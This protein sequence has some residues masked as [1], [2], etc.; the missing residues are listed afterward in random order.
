[1]GQEEAGACALSSLLIHNPVSY[2]P[3]TQSRHEAVATGVVLGG[4]KMRFPSK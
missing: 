4:T 3:W 2:K 1:M